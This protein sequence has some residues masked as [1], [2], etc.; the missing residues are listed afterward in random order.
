MAAINSTMFDTPNW[1]NQSS[2]INQ[3]S[4]ELGNIAYQVNDSLL[5]VIT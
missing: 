5:E 2:N 3:L 4:P 1:G